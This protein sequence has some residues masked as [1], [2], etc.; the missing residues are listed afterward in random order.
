MG[1]QFKWN[2][3]ADIKAKMVRQAAFMEDRVTLEHLV[4][5]KADLDGKDETGATPLHIA[6]TQNKPALVSWLLAKRADLNVKDGEGFSTLVWAC[7]KGHLDVVKI[8]IAA[9]ADPEEVVELTAKTPLSLACERGHLDVV[10][11]LLA[12]RA[13]VDQPNPDQSTPLM[14]A[15]HQGETEIVSL[16]LSR[17]AHVNQL[18]KDGWTALMYAMNGPAGVVGD[19]AEKRVHVD[20][21]LGKKSTPELLLL[22]KADVNVQS[23]DGLSPLVIAASHDWPETIKLLIQCNAQVNLPTARGQ[24]PLL[25]AVANDLPQVVRPLIIAAADV[26]HANLKGECAYSL[27]EKYAPHEVFDLLKKAGAA[28]PKKKAKAKKG[29]K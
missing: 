19:R 3:S 11:I 9:K 16:L 7:L 5:Q 21:V 28:A 10:K 6:A 23:G 27:A 12:Q 8:C 20:G 22:H 15:A 17:N 26:N 4:R 2:P 13:A 18:N 1:E 25:V 29:K 14:C 24:T